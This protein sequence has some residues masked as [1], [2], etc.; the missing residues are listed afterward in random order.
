MNRLKSCL[1][2]GQPTANPKFCSRSHAKSHYWATK[3]AQQ[4]TCNG[5]GELWNGWPCRTCVRRLQREW[6]RRWRANNP[7]LTRQT[8]R[9]YNRQKTVSQYNITPERFDEMVN[10]QYGCCAICKKPESRK[11]F[12]LSIDHDHTCCDTQQECCGDCVRGLLCG[13]CNLVLGWLEPRLKE[14]LGYL[15]YDLLDGNV[16]FLKSPRP[17]PLD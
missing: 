15:G 5:C 13:S 2:C 14:V 4:D 3:R 9:K 17:Q 1:H 7:E 10:E 6:R 16:A 8:A 11:G 12:S